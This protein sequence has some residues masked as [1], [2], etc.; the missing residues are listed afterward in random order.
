MC[1]VS[2]RLRSGKGPCPVV[3]GR[4]GG[5]E[6]DEMK[7]R[8]SRWRTGRGEGKGEAREVGEVRG[9]RRW[10]RRKK[11]KIMKGRGGGEQEDEME[12]M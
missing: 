12:E 4:R 8:G 2:L 11:K 6:G 1:L 9:G 5:E 10:K 7:G 3:E